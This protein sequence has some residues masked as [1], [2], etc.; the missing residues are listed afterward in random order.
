MGKTPLWNSARNSNY[1][2]PKRK[3]Q[4]QKPFW[5]TTK[6]E[7]KKKVNH[8]PPKDEKWESREEPGEMLNMLTSFLCPKCKQV[9]CDSCRAP[10]FWSM[11][12]FSFFAFRDFATEESHQQ[13]WLKEPRQLWLMAEQRVRQTRR[14]VREEVID[15]YQEAARETPTPGLWGLNV[16]A[17]YVDGRNRCSTFS[18]EQRP[19]API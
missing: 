16:F 19:L 9:A 12:N 4:A 13:I 11:H 7:K 3:G 10:H 18:K 5:H 14:E 1:E 6:E 15:H 17:T 8:F 2:K